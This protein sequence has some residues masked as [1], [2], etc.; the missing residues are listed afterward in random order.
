MK[1][2]HHNSEQWHA[3]VMPLW[4]R[5]LRWI[6]WL[7]GWEDIIHD[8]HGYRVQLRPRRWRPGARGWRG[9]YDSMTPIALVGHRIVFQWYGFRFSTRRGYLCVTWP[10]GD[11]EQWCVYWSPDSTPHSATLWLMGAPRDVRQAATMTG[12]LAE[13]RE[14]QRVA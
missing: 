8:R 11:S 14:R 12:R 3:N 9:V 10:S 7:G 2:Y 1:T 6:V 13:E 5:L 4:A